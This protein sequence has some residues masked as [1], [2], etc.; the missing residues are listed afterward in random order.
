MRRPTAPAVIES[1][2][3][4]LDDGPFKGQKILVVDDDVRNVFALTALL[5]RGRADVTVAGSGAEALA[6]LE[7]KPDIDLVLMDIMM[8]GMDGYTAIRAIRAIDR[9]ESL[10]IIA[11]SGKGALGESQRC[12]DAGAND[13]VPKPVDTGELVAAIVRWLPVPG[14]GAGSPFAMR[15]LMA[16]DDHASRLIAEAA[17]R[18]LGHECETVSDG[19]EAWEAF[20]SRSPDVVIS[21]WAMPGLTGL[22]LCRKIRAHAADSY[23]YFFLCTGRAG[24]DEI[25]QGHGRRGR[26]LPRQAARLATSSGPI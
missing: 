13:Y 12:V 17:L 23:T 11:V 22:E 7:R 2:H 5:Q 10:P 8:P 26:R 6:A 9:F 25:L 14:G 18:R 3:S 16:D 1:P 4:G 20:K 15:V 19:A 21:D 24:L